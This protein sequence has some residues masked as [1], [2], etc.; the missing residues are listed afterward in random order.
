MGLSQRFRG[1]KFG[2]CWRGPWASG[3]EADF[4]AIKR[5][6]SGILELSTGYQQVINR[7]LTG[8]QQVINRLSTGMLITFRMAAGWFSG[9]P[10]ALD[11]PWGEGLLGLQP[12]AS[13]RTGEKS[14]ERFGGLGGGFSSLW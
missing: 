4:S 13:R 8:Y 1:L 11:R 5:I 6:V 7:L 2:A 10:L 3:F 14:A 9:L 12:L